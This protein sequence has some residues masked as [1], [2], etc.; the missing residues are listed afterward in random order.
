MTR[1]SEA[2]VTTSADPIFHGIEVGHI[3]K[4]CKGITMW[5]FQVWL[6]ARSSHIS[7]FACD[8]Q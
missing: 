5:S 3:R 2:A 1:M 6:V 7:G 8:N 4:S